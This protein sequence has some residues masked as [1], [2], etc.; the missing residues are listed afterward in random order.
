[1]THLVWWTFGFRRRRVQLLRPLAGTDKKHG[2]FVR[3]WYYF[4]CRGRCKE[5]VVVVA[6]IRTLR[7]QEDTPPPRERREE[8]VPPVVVVGVA[9]RLTSAQGC[10][11]VRADKE[12]GSEPK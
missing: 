5:V 8:A 3:P 7:Q 2:T 9:C 6:W 12:I 1:M 11:R 4:K 10:D